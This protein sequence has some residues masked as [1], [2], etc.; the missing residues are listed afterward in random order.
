[1]IIWALELTMMHRATHLLQWHIVL[2]ERGLYVYYHRYG[3]F[4]I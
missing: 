4:L 2:M 1:M 3:H